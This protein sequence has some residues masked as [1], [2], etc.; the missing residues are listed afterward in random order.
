MTQMLLFIDID[1]SALEAVPRRPLSQRRKNGRQLCVFDL[2]EYEPRPPRPR[3]RADCA[4]GP[5]P[6]PWVGCRY[7]LFLD[8]NEDTGA[9]KFNFPGLEPWELEHSCA[10]DVAEAGEGTPLRLSELGE[11]YGVGPER[12]RQ[13]VNDALAS[14]H[15]VATAMVVEL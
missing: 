8:V 4:N 10:L 2:F 3:C 11:L 9:I 5:R 7:H 12:M 6:C 15:E 13:I 1:E 14:A